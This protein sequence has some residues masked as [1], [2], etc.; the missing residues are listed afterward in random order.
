MSMPPTGTSTAQRG[1]VSER[2][3]EVP[4]QRSGGAGPD[5]PLDLEGPDWRATLERT[6]KEIKDDRIT[7]A[8]AG[9]AYYFFLAIF[10]AFIALVGLLGLFNISPNGLADSITRTLPGE[11]GQVLAAPIK[12]ADRSSDSA[13]IVAAISGVA[14]ALWSAS[15]G[16]VG[17][18]SGL[19]IAYDVPHDRKFL[20]KRAVALVLLVA[21]GLLGGVP[22]PIFT[23]G[24]STVFVVLGWI[25][26]AFAL[27]VLF[28]I[29]YYMGPNREKPEWRWVSFG[30]VVGAALWAG[31]SIAFFTYIKSF[32]NYQKTYG[33]QVGVIVLILWLFVSSLAVLVGGE[34][35]AEIERQSEK[36]RRAEA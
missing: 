25:L 19:N 14:V 2:G 17:L 32:S 34:L 36:R 13:S 5:S 18:Q 7:L 20:G 31:S 1:D 26:T 16:M 27:T 35:N 21:T 11:A 23:F 30:G 10:P 33:S 24:E 22:S 4:P 6:L 3:G 28:S 29:F 12:A 9:M 15:S 8:A